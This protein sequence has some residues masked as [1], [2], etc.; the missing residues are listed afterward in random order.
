MRSFP[1]RGGRP[2]RWRWLLP[3]VAAAWAVA[4]V[5]AAVWSAHHDPP[6]VRA[7]S[8]LS[9]GRQVLD[10][11]VDAV[12]AAAGPGVVE[13][14]G[15]YRVST[16]C[17]L[18]LVR[19]GTDVARVVVLTVPPGQE[20]ALL[21]KLADRLPREWRPRHRG[22]TLYADAG[23]FV[24]VDGEAVAPGEVHVTARTGCR[25]GRDPVLSGTGSAGP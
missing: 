24:R 4:L 11:A 16:G 18:S 3:A 25:P 19:R 15:G 7:Q 17:R 9:R 2:G 21:D 12:V 20:A 8:D 22:G 1:W 13:R 6:T 5:A 14:V 23:E 10:E